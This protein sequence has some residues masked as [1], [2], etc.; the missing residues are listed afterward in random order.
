MSKNNHARQ[1][2]KN[3]K[4]SQGFLPSRWY[5]TGLLIIGL[6]AG[7]VAL[8]QPTSLQATPDP[9]VQKYG[10]NDQLP[11][12]NGYTELA[13]LPVN[14]AFWMAKD[15]WQVRLSEVYSSGKITIQAGFPNSLQDIS[16][17][18]NKYSIVWIHGYKIVIFQRWA[19][20]QDYHF[21]LQIL[22][23]K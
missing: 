9:E 18:T 2:V 17:D 4:L 12:P 23:G 7:I 1:V 16:V 21:W 11:V 20:D 14:S 5:W 8:S 6:V 13:Q 15:G 3:A 22:Q 10:L 19:N